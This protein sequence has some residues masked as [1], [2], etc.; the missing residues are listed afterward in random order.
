MDEL[1]EQLR[2]KIRER[3]AEDFLED[4]ILRFDG[5]F[6]S[7][8]I[9]KQIAAEYHDCPHCKDDLDTEFIGD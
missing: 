6:G 5:L 4:V 7:F 1:L 3:N 2:A 8:L 9:A